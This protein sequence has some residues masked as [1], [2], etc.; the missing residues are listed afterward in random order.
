MR[1]LRKKNDAVMKDGGW[2]RVSIVAKQFSVSRPTIYNW[3]YDGKIEGRRVDGVVYVD[4]KSVENLVK[5]AE[6]FEVEF[7]GSLVNEGYLSVSEASKKYAVT[8]QNIYA[9]IHSK[10][11]AAKQAKKSGHWYVLDQSMAERCKEGA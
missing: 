7:H 11:V 1:G 4:L 5:A 2:Y 6:S 10:K 9:W 3:L 8:R